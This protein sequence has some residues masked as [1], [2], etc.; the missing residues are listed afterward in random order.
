V[1]LAAESTGGAQQC[2]QAAVEYAKVRLQFG[3]P[4]GTFQAVKHKCAD[5]LLEVE[6]AKAAVYWASWVAS[7]RDEELLQAASVAKALSSDAYLLASAESIQ[8]HGG[9]G[10]TWEA[11]PQLYFKRART[12]EELLGDATY[13]RTRIVTL[14]G[15]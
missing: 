1:L 10:V 13:H 2:L 4:I 15:V 12:N 5:V 6:S 14:M 9:I 7:E 3:Q 11:D 8:I